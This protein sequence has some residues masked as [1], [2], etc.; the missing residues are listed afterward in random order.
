MKQR[1]RQTKF[2]H[3]LLAKFERK[4]SSIPDSKRNYIFDYICKNIFLP[5]KSN[6]NPMRYTGSQICNL[7]RQQKT[8]YPSDRKQMSCAQISMGLSDLVNELQQPQACCDD[9]TI[10]MARKPWKKQKENP[11]GCTGEGERQ[12]ANIREGSSSVWR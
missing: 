11:V 3:Y 1:C 10:K 2:I 6:G 8:D 9:N 12:K 4:R 7:P 5:K